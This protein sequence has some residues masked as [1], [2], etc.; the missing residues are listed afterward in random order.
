[1]IN[2]YINLNIMMNKG[3]Y[4]R[5]SLDH[6]NA[7]PIRKKILFDTSLLDGAPYYP[8]FDDGVK[9]QVTEEFMVPKKA[10]VYFIHDLRGFL[11][12]GEANNIR[13]RFL[14]H[15][16]REKNIELIKLIN[17]PFG[18]LRFYWI[19]TNTKP[20][21]VK[22]QKYWIRILKPHSNKITYKKDRS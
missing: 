12:I 5:D 22:L 7:E 13:N 17:Y 10:G 14:Q 2:R 20:R 9:Y 1:M 8:K 21:A 16:Q 15:L 6:K 19:K 18:D 4:N 11:Y 3:N